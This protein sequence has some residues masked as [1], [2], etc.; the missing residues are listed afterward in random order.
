MLIRLYDLLK[1]LVDTTR[2]QKN[3]HELTREQKHISSLFV[4]TDDNVGGRLSYL[5]PPARV[6][7]APGIRVGVLQRQ[8]R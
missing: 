7:P 6:R 3:V 4:A 8:I 2:T 1:S 5:A